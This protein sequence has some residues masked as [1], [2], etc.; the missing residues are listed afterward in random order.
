M[1]I[2][3]S[4]RSEVI[5]NVTEGTCSSALLS[6]RSSSMPVSAAISSGSDVSVFFSSS[7]SVRRVS[8]PSQEGTS[9]SFA[10]HRYSD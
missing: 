3:S 7:S 10:P 2:K 6:R 9:V 1:S 8:P 4:L 5:A